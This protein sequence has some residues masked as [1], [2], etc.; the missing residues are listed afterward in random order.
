METHPSLLTVMGRVK[1]WLRQML[2]FHPSHLPKSM[3]GLHT[4][5][6]NLCCYYV[7]VD[8]DIVVQHLIDCHVLQGSPENLIVN[9]SV[10][11]QTWS[12]HPVLQRVFAWLGRVNPPTKLVSLKQALK[13]VCTYKSQF[14]VE[15]VIS[16]LRFAGWVEL[17]QEYIS[18]EIPHKRKEEDMQSVESMVPAKKCHV[19][20]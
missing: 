16:E 3:E 19:V 9:R 2:L 11:S 12:Q 14:S 15:T 4:V 1:Q 13:A 7:T 18:Y 8:V 6:R 10:L 20:A 5:L 17:H